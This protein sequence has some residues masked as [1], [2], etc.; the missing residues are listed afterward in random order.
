MSFFNFFGAMSNKSKGIVIPNN[1]SIKPNWNDSCVGVG[2]FNLNFPIKLEKVIVNN[3]DQEEEIAKIDILKKKIYFNEY[4]NANTFY[5]HILA[6]E[7]LEGN[8]EYQSKILLEVELNYYKRQ[9]YTGD[10]NI[11]YQEFKAEKHNKEIDYSEIP[12]V[13]TV[14][15]GG[16]NEF[17]HKSP[18]YSRIE[19][20]SSLVCIERNVLFPDQVD[21]L[22]NKDEKI[23]IYTSQI[24]YKIYINHLNYYMFYLEFN[25][26]NV[27]TDL[28]YAFNDKIV[29]FD[30]K[31]MHY[32]KMYMEET[33][34]N[35]KKLNPN[36]SY[37]KLKILENDEDYFK[38]IKKSI[39]TKYK[40]ED[41]Q[42]ENPDEIFGKIINVNLKIR[43]VSLAF[44]PYE[45]ENFQKIET[46][47]KNLNKN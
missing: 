33:Y 22:E 41:T 2:C 31:N 20:I 7:L 35:I 9:I 37:F 16:N 4:L 10:E 3:G 36:Q 23:G 44:A 32:F 42:E 13:Y 39:I 14:K 6:L 38:F 11:D 29:K 26:I 47:Y 5:Y 8:N 40:L 17:I 43:C 27:N 12:T 18:Y 30:K 15:N 46:I 24:F 21:I 1:I 34:M 19:K 45:N 28:E 25:K